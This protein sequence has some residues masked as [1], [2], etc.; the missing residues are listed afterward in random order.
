VNPAILQSLIFVLFLIFVIVSPGIRDRLPRDFPLVGTGY[1]AIFA[2]LGALFQLELQFRSPGVFL[3]ASLLGLAVAAAFRKDLRSGRFSIA[4]WN[5]P[6]EAK[7]L[8]NLLF[9]LTGGIVIFLFLAVNI[10]FFLLS[11]RS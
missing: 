8:V 1:L 6:D 11:I 4:F 7:R 3:S 10:L 5:M 9:G 2:L